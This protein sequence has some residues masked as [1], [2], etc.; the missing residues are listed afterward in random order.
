MQL[1][2]GE[3]CTSIPFGPTTLRKGLSRCQPESRLA[4]MWDSET[5]WRTHGGQG[6]RAPRPTKP[7]ILTL[8]KVVTIRYFEF[9]KLFNRQLF[10]SKYRVSQVVTRAA[11]QFVYIYNKPPVQRAPALAQLVWVLAFIKSK[12]NK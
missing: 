10:K 11:H 3:Y 12:S 1:S 6:G 2:S 8:V 9:Y 7:R 5:Q 4:K